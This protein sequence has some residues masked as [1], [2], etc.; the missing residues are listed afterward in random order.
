M[1]SGQRPL[2]VQP[3]ADLR[4]EDLSGLDLTGCDEVLR[5]V[6]FDTRT[7]WPEPVQMPATWDPDEVLDLG[8][9][10]GLSVRDLHDCGIDGHGVH[11]AI[12]DQ[13]LDPGH[14]DFRHAM[15]SSVV[16][17]QEHPDANESWWTTQMHGPAVTSLLA[18]RTCGTAPAVRVHYY[19][20]PMWVGYEYTI[21]ALR[22]VIDENTNRPPGKETRIVSVSTGF[23]RDDPLFP[24][25]LEALDDAAQASV[26]VVHCSKQLGYAGCDRGS[27]P[28]DPAAYRLA[29]FYEIAGDDASDPEDEGKLFV[30]CDNRTLGS[31]EG[32]QDFAFF[33]SGGGS[34]G[35]PWLAGVI[36]MGL[37]VRSDLTED[38]CFALLRKTGTPFREGTLTNAAGFVDHLLLA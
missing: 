30:P 6:D 10:P 25:W 13:P 1:G 24:Q 14:M 5:T 23:K 34:W 12:I 27:N 26:I 11:V 4:G 38:E 20:H 22:M 8:R 15:A 19:A 7:L 33:A 18:G 17:G 35:V 16:I 32:P 31:P 21:A 29:S 36:A 2:A 9:N 3:W 37:Q 28:D